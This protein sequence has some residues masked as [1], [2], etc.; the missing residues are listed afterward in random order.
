[1]VPF[2]I[3]GRVDMRHELE[4]ERRPITVAPLLVG[5]PLA[6]WLATTLSVSPG[7]HLG[8]CIWMGSAF[9]GAAALLML[10]L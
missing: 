9:L 4:P 7:E 6:W 8:G 2:L 5:P 3:I 1:M 10:A